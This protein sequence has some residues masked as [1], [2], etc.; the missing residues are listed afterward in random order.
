MKKA[1]AAREAEAVYPP[2]G[3]KSSAATAFVN[4]NNPSGSECK[5][6]QQSCQNQEA[7]VLTGPN[8]RSRVVSAVADA[9]VI[10]VG[11]WFASDL[12]WAGPWTPGWPA[13]C[14]GLRLAGSVDGLIAQGIEQWFPKPCVAGSI[15]AGA[16]HESIVRFFGRSRTKEE[17]IPV[18]GTRSSFVQAREMLGLEAQ[19]SDQAFATYSSISPRNCAFSTAGAHEISTAF[20]ASWAKNWSETLPSS[21]TR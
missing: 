12:S 19:S 13:R 18:L 11:R 4:N 14:L 6:H 7:F 20:R 15:P 5:R 8:T 21:A 9:S 10:A 1:A 2:P 3:D 16:A 17:R